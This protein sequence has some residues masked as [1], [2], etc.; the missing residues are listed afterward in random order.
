MVPVLVGVVVLAAVAAAV[1]LLRRRAPRQPVI[2]PFTIS[3]RWRRHVAAALAAQRTYRELVRATDPGPLRDRLDTVERQVQHAVT[4]IWEIAQRG[5]ELDEALSALNTPALTARAEHTTDAE[6]KASLQAQLDSASRLR[7]T[8]DDTD[9]RLRLLTTR[10]GELVAQAA[11]VSVGSDDT[12]VLGTAVDDVV[13]QLEALRLAI[14]DVNHTGRS[15]S[16]P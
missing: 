8:R 10:M 9:A 7:S 5:D 15:A 2:D 14:N 11:E 4:E 3:E 12:D 1:V 6:T 13:T 16:S